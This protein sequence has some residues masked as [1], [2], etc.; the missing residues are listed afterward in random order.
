M[1]NLRHKKT[2]HEKIDIDTT[3]TRTPILPV[4][5]SFRYYNYNYNYNKTFKKRKQNNKIK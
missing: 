2:M 3:V 5:R 4:V 1:E